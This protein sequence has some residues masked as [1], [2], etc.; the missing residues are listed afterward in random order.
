MTPY[1]RFLIFKNEF[2]S[3]WEIQVAPFQWQWVPAL[4]VGNWSKNQ[5]GQKFLALT[6]F[7]YGVANVTK[8]I[9]N[10]NTIYSI[11]HGSRKATLIYRKQP[12]NQ[13]TTVQWATWQTEGREPIQVIGDAEYIQETIDEIELFFKP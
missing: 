12:E 10:E 13:H 4:I 8:Q 5:Y 2:L 6:S 11:T 3:G 9:D 1:K 7:L